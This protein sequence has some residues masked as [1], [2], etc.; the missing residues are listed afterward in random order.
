MLARKYELTN[1]FMDLKY[2][3][4]ILKENLDIPELR[5]PQRIARERGDLF[6]VPLTEAGLMRIPGQNN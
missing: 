4:L 2:Y 3:G 6:S 5:C 1:I